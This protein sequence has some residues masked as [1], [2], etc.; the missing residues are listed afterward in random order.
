VAKVGDTLGA[1]AF[2]EVAHQIFDKFLNPRIAHRPLLI[3]PFLLL[4]NSR[5]VVDGDV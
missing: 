1:S 5:L 2:E 3:F 4:V